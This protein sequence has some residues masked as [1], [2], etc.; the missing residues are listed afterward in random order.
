MN[1]KSLNV[2]EQYDIEVLGTRRGRGSYICETSQGKKL[3]T[4]SESSE[5]KLR[6]TNRVLELLRLR[7]YLYADLVLPNKEG[8]LLTPGWDGELCI[9]KD[10]YE[11]RECDARSTADAEAAVRKLAK[12]HKW[13]QLPQE[14]VTDP[15]GYIEEKFSEEILRHNRELLKICAFMRKKKR[16]SEF[17][18]L[19]LGCFSM[20]YEQ[21]QAAA[22]LL[23]GQEY[24]ALRGKSISAGL[25][26]H[27]SFHHHNIWFPGR[28]QVFIGNFEHCRYG[29]QA[30]DL[31]QLLRKVMEKQDWDVRA[32]K[33]I[34][35]AYDREKALTRQ[36]RR[37]LYVRL[38]YPEKFWKLA[39]QY[40][41]RRKAWIPQKD[42]EKLENMIRQY[43]TR[44][45]FLKTLE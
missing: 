9:L 30:S 20:F 29:V 5:K 3:L 41:N 27:G 19:F 16:K 34:L 15:A 6:F 32:G 21:A 38:L 18:S 44:N 2:L 11:G 37:F 12:L 45:S 40:Y 33:R 35:E 1:E 10:W 25:L 23:E 17:E 26:C 8:N 36:E 7:G 31:Y 24:G 13:M 42:A 43:K 22:E 39:N 14:E 4:P 28:G